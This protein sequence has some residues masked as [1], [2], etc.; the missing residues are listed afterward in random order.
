M[1]L[2]VNPN[3]QLSLTPKTLDEAMR[4]A[5]LMS[6]SNIVPKDYQGN[7]GNVLVAVQWGMEVGLQ[8]LQ[9]M[10][11]IAVINGRPSL[12]GDAVIALV[13]S[14]S[15][16]EYINETATD[17]TATCTVKRR[18]EDETYRTF[19]LDHAKKAGLL[20]KAGP[21]S[22]YPQ[23]M[24]QMRARSWALRDVFPDVLKGMI[25]AEEAMDMTPLE[26]EVNPNAPAN[27]VKADD[28]YQA[29]EDV[30]LQ[31]LRDASFDGMESLKAAFTRIP[32]N[33]HKQTLWV[34]HGSALK[35]SA[36][37][38]DQNRVVQPDVDTSSEVED[39]VH[40]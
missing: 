4:F 7:P 36:I 19:T 8:P 22:Q 23:R 38:S 39:S 9:A 11:N 25:V 24:M 3:S 40:D 27:R 16:C 20:G 29:F 17:T 31:Q 5:E 21:W 35:S 2:T 30:N 18:G 12:W 14:S 15:L 28:G 1:E 13:R 10:Q 32:A 33:Q 6:K 37:Q 26:K 34:K